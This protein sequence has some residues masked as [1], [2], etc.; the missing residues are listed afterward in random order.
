MLAM[1]LPSQCRVIAEHA[2]LS[3]SWHIAASRPSHSLPEN[4]PQPAH[5]AV[6]STLGYQHS[7]QHTQA[8]V[9]AHKPT[10]AHIGKIA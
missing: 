10:G 4:K 6:K 8:N 7:R 9:T 1:A 3:P 5:S 2:K